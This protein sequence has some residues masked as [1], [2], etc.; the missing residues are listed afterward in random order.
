MHTILAAA[1][2]VPLLRCCLLAAA[3]DAA[4]LFGG[5]EEGGGPRREQCY[6]ID[7]PFRSGDDW[8][9][10]AGARPRTASEARYIGHPSGRMYGSRGPTVAPEPAAA[11]E[12]DD[13]DPPA[14]ILLFASGVTT[15]AEVLRARSNKEPS[16]ATAAGTKTLLLLQASILVQAYVGLLKQQ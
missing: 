13:G 8:S 7:V 5:G 10:G 1:P 15:T 4:W 6:Y 12:D 16:I 14:I 9:A 3:A 2:P 11:V